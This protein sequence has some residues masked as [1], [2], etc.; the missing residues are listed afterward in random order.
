VFIEEKR[1]SLST[2]PKIYLKVQFRREHG[3][4]EITVGTVNKTETVGSEPD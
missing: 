1:T 3:G 2:G 4:Q